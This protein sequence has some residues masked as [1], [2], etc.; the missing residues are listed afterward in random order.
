MNAAL[1][2][3]SSLRLVDHRLTRDPC[4]AFQGVAALSS[5]EDAPARVQGHVPALQRPPSLRPLSNGSTPGPSPE[6]SAAIWS[7]P[8]LPSVLD[9]VNHKLRP[10]ASANHREQGLGSAS[11]DVGDAGAPLL[12]ELATLQ[13]RSRSGK[14]AQQQVQHAPCSARDVNRSLA[15]QC[16]RL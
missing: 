4:V 1:C 13:L 2:S 7:P 3:H 16:F 5:P 10:V 9:V 15:C 6:K 11:G 14:A 12:K 8:P